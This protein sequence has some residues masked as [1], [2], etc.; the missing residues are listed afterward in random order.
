MV[1]VMDLPGPPSVQKTNDKVNAFLQ[2][3]KKYAHDRRSCDD[4]QISYLETLEEHN[5]DT[6]WLAQMIAQ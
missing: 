1:V 4:V 6:L 3:V 5:N 2:L